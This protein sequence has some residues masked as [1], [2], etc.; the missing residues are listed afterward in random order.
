MV[1]RVK[2][3]SRLQILCAETRVVS[4]LEMTHSLIEP[5]AFQVSWLS[6]FREYPGAIISHWTRMSKI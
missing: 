6:A 2:V 5:R 4:G 3:S 1:G